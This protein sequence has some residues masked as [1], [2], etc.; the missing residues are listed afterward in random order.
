VPIVEVT[1]TKDSGWVDITRFL[2]NK[3]TAIKVQV[4]NTDKGK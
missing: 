3:E 1:Y 2:N 4:I